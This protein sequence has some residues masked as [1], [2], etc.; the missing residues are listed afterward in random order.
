MMGAEDAT[1]SSEVLKVVHDNCD[2][3]IQHEKTTEEHERSKICLKNS[4]KIDIKNSN[5]KNSTYVRDYISTHFS[6]FPL[7]TFRNQ[8]SVITFRLYAS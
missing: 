2:K 4:K 7:T 1:I 8:C 5:Y 6:V 3:Q